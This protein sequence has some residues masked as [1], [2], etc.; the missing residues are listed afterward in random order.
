MTPN[1]STRLDPR[2]TRVREISTYMDALR[3]Q[4]RKISERSNLRPIIID[5]L[6][7]CTDACVAAKAREWAISEEK[8]RAAKACASAVGITFL[9]QPPAEAA[10]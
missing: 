4:L 3:A 7:K 9:F 10:E 2:V 5:A 1:P 8:F 6:D